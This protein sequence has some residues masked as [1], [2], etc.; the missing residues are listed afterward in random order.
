VN[1]RVYAAGF[2]VKGVPRA[3]RRRLRTHEA[4]R[5]RGSPHTELRECAGVYVA[6]CPRRDLGRDSSLRP[7]RGLGWLG[8]GRGA[9]RTDCSLWRR[10][11][12]SPDSTGVFE[13]SSS[14]SPTTRCPAVAF[15]TERDTWVCTPPLRQEC[16]VGGLVTRFF[17]TSRRSAATRMKDPRFATVLAST[18]GSCG[19]CSGGPWSARK[20]GE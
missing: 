12:S 17:L 3:R 15:P 11:R 19:G 7:R 20:L 6:R 18:S 8:S 2:G 14:D 16:G 9:T 13:R 5:L 1:S 10:S 4:G